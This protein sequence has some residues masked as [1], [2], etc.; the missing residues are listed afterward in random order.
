VNTLIDVANYKEEQIRVPHDAKW[1]NEFLGTDIPESEQ[2]G[3]F[4]RLGLGYENG[5][6]IAPPWRSDIKL[7]CDLAEEVARIYGYNRI[8]SA[9]S[10]RAVSDAFEYNT[11]KLVNTLIAQGCSE[12]I[13]YS[14]VSP[15]MNAIAGTHDAVVLRNP[16]G[17]ETSVMRTSMIG[18]MLRVVKDNLNAGNSEMRLFE[19]G[20]IYAPNSEPDTLCVA[21]CGKDEDFYTLKGIIEELLSVFRVPLSIQRYT[22]APFHSGRAASCDYAVFGE[23]SP[24]VLR[25]Y[26]FGESERVYVAQ[27]DVEGFFGQINTKLT[28]RQIPKY[29]DSVRDLSLVCD[30]GMASGRVIEMIQKAVKSNLESVEFF[31]KFDLGEG[32][33]SLSYK[34]TFRKTDSTLTGEEVDKAIS[35]ILTVLE[36]NN[37]RLRG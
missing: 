10:S 20:R 22:E 23:V 35:K 7:P 11:R 27:I 31:D 19:L 36:Q 28:F 6:V 5:E 15:A 32:K 37:I 25:E 3:I 24:L 2:V 1:I 13:T 9:L 26:G 8:S 18:S 29:P 16:F 17:E 34:L 21:L 30:E 14:F 33:K 12:C 4:A